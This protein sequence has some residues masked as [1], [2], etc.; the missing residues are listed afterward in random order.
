[1]I[2]AHQYA[3]VRRA[4]I[5]GVGREHAD[6]RV[7]MYFER[8][9]G[10]TIC[11]IHLPARHIEK[12]LE[13]RV[14]EQHMEIVALKNRIEHLENVI[15]GMQPESEPHPDTARL[16]KLQLLTCG[17]G[18]GWILRQSTTGRGMR[19]HETGQDGALPNV[20]SAI[21]AY[22]RP[23]IDSGDDMAG[24]H[25]EYPHVDPTEESDAGVCPVL[26]PDGFKIVPE[27]NTPVPDDVTK[28]FELASLFRAIG[29]YFDAAALE[30]T[31][32]RDVA[33]LLEKMANELQRQRERN[34]GE[35]VPEVVVVR[36]MN[37]TGEVTKG[38][39][40]GEFYVLDD[41]DC[42]TA[43]QLTA[44]YEPEF[45]YS[46][47]PSPPRELLERIAK[48]EKG[49]E[50]A[51]HAIDAATPDDCM[52]TASGDGKEWMIKDEVVSNLRALLPQEPKEEQSKAD[53]PNDWDDI[54]SYGPSA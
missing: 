13:R 36:N 47:P 1:M 49:L 43:D 48:L 20:R 18:G 5:D 8:N 17:H 12:L 37:Y 29:G 30:Q 40:D 35:T 22:A 6:V 34:E 42:Y 39:W 38:K 27:P 23:Q 52:G 45:Y 16:D 7:P 51:I 9:A 44:E 41:G 32:C 53:R 14:S 31:P 26:V 10:E 33:E 25:Y 54:D 15:T 50:L 11:M 21:D 4:G 24:M 3:D 2:K 46:R 19:L 28:A